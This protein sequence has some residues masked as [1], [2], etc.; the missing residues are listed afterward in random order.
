M[1]RHWWAAAQPSSA[2]VSCSL[3]AARVMGGTSRTSL[4][5]VAAEDTAST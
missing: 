5:A 2:D 4:N 3:Q 1:C